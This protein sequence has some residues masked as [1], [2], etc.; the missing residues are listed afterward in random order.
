MKTLET[1][2]RRL[3]DAKYSLFDI[4]TDLRAQT[5]IVEVV[6]RSDGRVEAA[7]TEIPASQASP[8]AGAMRVHKCAHAAAEASKELE[9]LNSGAVNARLESRGISLRKLH[10]CTRTRAEQP[11]KFGII[12]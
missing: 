5:E 10:K 3:W 8:E 12:T 6:R 11:R 9:K 4:S 2:H 7:G 1:H